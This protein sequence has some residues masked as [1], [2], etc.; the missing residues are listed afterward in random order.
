MGGSLVLG[1]IICSTVQ[2]HDRGRFIES[3]VGGK[4]CHYEVKRGQ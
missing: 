2:V 4:V 3:G 1:I